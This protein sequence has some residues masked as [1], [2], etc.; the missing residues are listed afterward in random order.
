MTE[1]SV[2][3]KKHSETM[4]HDK[5]A[6]LE[7]MNL[8]PAVIDFIRKNKRTLQIAIVVIILCVIGWE[9]YGKYKK[10]QLENSSAML[11]EA[12][13]T[14]SI[15][16]RISQLN[17]LSVQY[18]GKSGSGVWGSIELGH[19]AFDQMKYKE[20]IDHYSKA[21]EDISTQNPIYP[22]LQYSLAQTYENFGDSGSA[23]NIYQKL[24]DI[25]GFAGEGYMGM[26]RLAEKEGDSTKA[27]GYYQ[28]FLN[29]ADT[30]P[31]PAKDWADAK[32]AKLGE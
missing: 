10:T 26:A 5:K 32:I 14:E 29:L 15:D 3:T 22:L 27:V 20:A 17:A 8:P 2:F 28:N 31:G 6:I 18:A 21:L 1:Q 9:G 16:E 13:K 19:I 7:E 23:E 24:I 25:S 12:V 11:Y 4:E 30:Q